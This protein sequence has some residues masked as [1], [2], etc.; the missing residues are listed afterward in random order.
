MFIKAFEAA[1]RFFFGTEAISSFSRASFSSILWYT[2]ALIIRLSNEPFSSVVYQI[3]FT[4]Q[5]QSTL[6]RGY[7]W[8]LLDCVI[9]AIIITSLKQRINDISFQILKTDLYRALPLSIELADIA[10]EV[11]EFPSHLFYVVLG[12]KYLLL[13][14]TTSF[15]GDMLTDADIFID[16]IHIESVLRRLQI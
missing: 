11:H 16:V 12:P 5:I 7:L 14:K 3:R 8:P 10:Q 4:R 1:T 15:V 2:I 13:L 6:Y 9:L